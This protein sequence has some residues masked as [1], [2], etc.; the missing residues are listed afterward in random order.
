VT[1][2]HGDEDPEAKSADEVLDTA[3]QVELVE[4]DEIAVREKIEVQKDKV[5]LGLQKVVGWGALF[6]MIL[7]LGLADLVFI[8]YADSKG[9]GN[10]PT[11]AIQ[12]WLGATVIQV[13]AVVLIIARSL[14]PQGGRRSE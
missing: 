12:A 8:K 2:S 3:T 14:Y 6:V 4:R 11:G 10:I 13:V 9:W 1:D 7:Q 5:D